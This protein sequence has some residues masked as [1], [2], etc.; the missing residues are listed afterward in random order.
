MRRQRCGTYLKGGR[1][2]DIVLPP[3]Q[4]NLKL[5]LLLLLLLLLPITATS[6]ITTRAMMRRQRCGT[7]LRWGMHTDSSTATTT[8]P[9]TTTATATT[10]YYYLLLL[11]PLSLL[12]GW[13]VASDTVHTWGGVWIK[14][15][16]QPLLLN[17]K[18][19]LLLLLLPATTC[20]CYF[21]SHYLTDDVAPA[22]R[23]IPEGGYA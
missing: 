19:L 16:L 22:M 20:Y 17:L 23:Y 15:V 21:H 4:L 8:Q 12:D 9:T 1:H 18:R 5:L 13:C 11:L 10:T 6:T 2:K 3:L 7:C 14:I